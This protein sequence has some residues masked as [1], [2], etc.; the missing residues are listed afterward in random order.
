MWTYPDTL[1]ENNAFLNNNG[2]NGGAIYLS[3]ARA[4][5]KGNLIYGNQ[6]GHGGGVGIASG[7]AP[8]ILSGNWIWG[9]SAESGGGV[10]I[11]YNPTRLD[12]NF[13]VENQATRDG[14]GIYVYEAKPVLVHN[15]LARNIG[16]DGSGVFV[17]VSAEVALTN[18]I[19]VSHTVG[20]TVTS[21]STA[22]LEATLWGSGAWGNGTD[23]GGGGA[24]FTGTVD[25]WGDPV[26]VDPG[27]GDYHISPDSAAVNAGVDAGVTT[28]VDG[29]PRPV[30]SGYDIGADEYSASAP[31]SF[32]FSQAA[33]STPEG[34]GV[35]ITVERINGTAGAVSVQYATDDGTAISGS[36]YTAASGTLTFSP[37]QTSQ[38][39][40]V[41]VTGDTLDEA[42]ET[43][44]VDLRSL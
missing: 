24:I 33:Y 10:Y 5:I 34:S 6:G 42:D 31:G 44:T 43:F 36:D 26:F 1:L 3:A 16:G 20:I 22:T 21:G 41:S 35:V 8:A 18:T 40:T 17:G 4:T 9:N 11:W 23:W 28:D 30:G 32:R 15:T 39:V 19:I 12:N 2:S 7:S 29:D 27:G 14:A 13:I 25:I 37:G 38:T